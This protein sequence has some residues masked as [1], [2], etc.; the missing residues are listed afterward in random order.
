MERRLVF[1]AC[2]LAAVAV[3]ALACS[4]SPTATGAPEQWLRGKRF[5]VQVSFTRQQVQLKNHSDS[6]AD[7]S[8]LLL[9]GK[10]RHAGRRVKQLTSA[11]SELKT[12]E[13]F[14]VSVGRLLGAESKDQLSELR[15]EIGMDLEKEIFLVQ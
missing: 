10:Y 3:A 13:E 1:W 8:P 14:S 7:Y 5:S 2:V 12:G 6:G 9:V 4:A 11:K 15:I